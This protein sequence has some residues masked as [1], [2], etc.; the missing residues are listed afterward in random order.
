MP[1]VFHNFSTAAVMMAGRFARAIPALALAGLAAQQIRKR[2][3][4]NAVPTDGPLF[5]VLLV[6]TALIAGGLRFFPARTRG[7]M[8]I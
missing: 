3:V 5:V 4:G 2:K 1:A 7:P 6:A 8:L